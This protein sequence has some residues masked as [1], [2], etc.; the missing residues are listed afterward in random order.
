MQFSTQVKCWKSF[1]NG[2]EKCFGKSVRVLLY[3]A[4]VLLSEQLPFLFLSL[5]VAF[6]VFSTLSLITILSEQCLDSY[7]QQRFREFLVICMIV[8]SLF[9]FWIYLKWLTVR[10]AW[11]ILLKETVPPSSAANTKLLNLLEK[12]KLE[13]GIR[14]DFFIFYYLEVR[15]MEMKCLRAF[16]PGIQQF[17]LS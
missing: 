10:K 2:P 15:C 12:Y 8:P 7:F 6:P 3:A 4:C 13:Y 17:M 11:A 1:K 14:N 5:S 16:L 9:T